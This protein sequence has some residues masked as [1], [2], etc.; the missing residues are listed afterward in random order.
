MEKDWP[1]ERFKYRKGRMEGKKRESNGRVGKT[2]MLCPVSIY[3][4]HVMCRP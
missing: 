1:W 3:K 2:F 4:R